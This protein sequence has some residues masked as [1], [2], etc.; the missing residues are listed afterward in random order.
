MEKMCQSHL[1]VAVKGPVQSCIYRANGFKLVY[2]QMGA[3]H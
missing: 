1:I 3:V 2:V